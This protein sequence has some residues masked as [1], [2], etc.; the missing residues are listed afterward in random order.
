MFINSLF[1]PGTLK[2]DKLGNPRL[3]I[4]S[5]SPKRLFAAPL[6]EAGHVVS[7]IEERGYLRIIPGGYGHRVSM[8]H[9]FMQDKQVSIG[10][11]N[12]TISGIAV[13]PSSHYEGLSAI[14]ENIKPVYKWQ[15][16]FIDI[17][18]SSES[19]V[20]EKGIRLLDPLTTRKKPV[21]IADAFIA[22]PSVSSKAAV[23]A[24]VAVAKTLLR[25]KFSSCCKN[26]ADK[27][28]VNCKSFFDFCR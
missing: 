5:G 20:G 24:L 11:Q 4:G 21:I 23:I 19:A 7:A 16:K 9:Q 10:T 18:V 22:A 26:W 27:L 17:G 15:E 25:E 14:S 3:T 6:D 8:Y 2:K 28:N 1:A 13:V 12:S